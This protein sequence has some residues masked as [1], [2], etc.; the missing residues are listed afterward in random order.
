MAGE[1][2]GQQEWVWVLVEEPEKGR[3]QLLGQYDPDRDIQF[4]VVFPTKEDAQEGLK[5][6]SQPESSPYE[7]QAMRLDAVRKEAAR[8]GFRLVLVDGAGHLLQ[9]IDP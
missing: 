3:A 1:K 9:Q 5:R 4:V 2:A 6:I 7:P 8:G